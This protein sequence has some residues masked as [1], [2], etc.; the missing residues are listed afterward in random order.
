MLRPCTADTD[1]PSQEVA[2]RGIYSN[3]IHAFVTSRIDY[4]N[5]VLAESPRATTDKLQRVM[6]VAARVITNTQKYDSGLS[7]LLHEELHWLDALI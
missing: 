3:N 1:T 7:L 2:R 6:N 5:V 4:C